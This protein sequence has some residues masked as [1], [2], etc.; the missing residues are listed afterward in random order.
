MKVVNKV[1]KNLARWVAEFMGSWWSVIIFSS[2]ILLWILINTSRFT[3]TWHIDNYP[4]SFLNLILGI[5]AALTGPLVLIGN[6]SQEKR[7]QRLI[8]SIYTM[9]RQ[10]QNVLTTILEIETRQDVFFKT[11]PKAKPKTKPKVEPKAG[12]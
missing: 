7:Y 6:K 2:I 8:E 12:Q 1:F 10:Q 3:E 11:K 5:F 9:E 4:Y